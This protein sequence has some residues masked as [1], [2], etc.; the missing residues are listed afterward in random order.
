MNYSY[1]MGI[2]PS[3]NELKKIGFI[4]ETD[5]NNF[6]V[7]FPKEKSGIWESFIT[8]HLTFGYWN[9]YLTE[10]GVVFL[11]HL[12]SGIKKYIVHNYE[13]DEVHNLCERLCKRKFES[14]KDMLIGNH[15]YKDKIK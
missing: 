9:E 3:I 2:D 15:F 6:M 4:V 10:N 1:V 13:N 5:K 11:F 8:E 14:I 7:S 12:E